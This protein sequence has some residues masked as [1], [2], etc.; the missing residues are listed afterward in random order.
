MI[1]LTATGA[2]GPG[3]LT[4]EDC[5]ARDGAGTGAPPSRIAAVRTPDEIDPTASARAA[6]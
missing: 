1:N 2:D 4:L 5:A 3:Y 6:C